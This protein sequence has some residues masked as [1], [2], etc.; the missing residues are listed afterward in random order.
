MNLFLTLSMLDS[1]HIIKTEPLDWYADSRVDTLCFPLRQLPP[2]S[3]T[4]RDRRS[5]LTRAVAR[6]ITEERLQQQACSAL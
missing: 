5:A 2:L 1:R 3:M 6:N 4:S